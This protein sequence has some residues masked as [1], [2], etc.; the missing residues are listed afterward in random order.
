MSGGS[1]YAPL[2]PRPV[3]G[4]DKVLKKFQDKPTTK[5]QLSFVDYLEAGKHPRD[6]ALA[7]GYT[8]LMAE[9][10]SN[11]ILKSP[12]V[13]RELAQRGL[14]YLEDSGMKD[15][16]VAISKV[17]VL[18]NANVLDYYRLEHDPSSGREVPV[19]DLGSCSRD[20]MYAVK[21]IFFDATGKPHVELYDKPKALE[22]LI[23]I[24]ILQKEREKNP[25]APLTIQALDDL[26]QQVTNIQVNNYYS[27][28]K[29]EQQTDSE[30]AT[31]SLPPVVGVGDSSQKLLPTS[32]E[33]G[34]V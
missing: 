33:S 28:K 29:S 1:S 9:Q 21:R 3:K 30:S 23:K 4:K 20:Q 2:T 5:K 12:G 16:E 6:A 11:V 31:I 14:K 25:N 15:P 34:T 24:H 8:P 32:E 10:A 27:T 17:A 19:L 26:V 7:A 18:A 22:N 13:Q